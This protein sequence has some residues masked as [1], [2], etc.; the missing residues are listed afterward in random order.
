M[1][2]PPR[3]PSTG[4][5]P[6]WVTQDF[7]AWLPPERLEELALAFGTRRSAARH[8]LPL[9]I[10]ATFLTARDVPEIGDALYAAGLDAAVRV[11][12]SSGDDDEHAW[13]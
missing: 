1:P 2:P 10:T 3:P 13:S 9:T 6:N 8:P 11:R 12:S 7:R 5:E 4:V